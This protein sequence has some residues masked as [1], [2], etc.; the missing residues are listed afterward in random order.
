MKDW[1]IIHIRKAAELEDKGWRLVAD[2]IALDDFVLRARRKQFR[3]GTTWLW[4]IA[5]A[6]SPPAPRE[7]E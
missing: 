2:N 5:Q 7:G 1:R 6:W 3:P 4:A